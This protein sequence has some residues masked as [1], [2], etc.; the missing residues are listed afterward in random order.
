MRGCANG[1]KATHQPSKTTAKPSSIYPPE[2]LPEVNR[3][4]NTRDHQ[5]TDLVS[6]WPSLGP[7]DR[8]L[9]LL[10][11]KRSPPTRTEP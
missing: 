1:R 2:V 4:G 5:L 6:L 3:F 7:P 8:D 9:I 11:A 10:V